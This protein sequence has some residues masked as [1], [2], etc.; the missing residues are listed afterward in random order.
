MKTKL[1]KKFDENQGTITAAV[2]EDALYYGYD[3]PQQFFEDLL[4]HGCQWGTVSSMI[5][6]YDTHKFYDKHYDEIEDIRLELQEEWI[7]WNEPIDSDLKNYY[8]WLA[9]EHVAYN[10]YNELEMEGS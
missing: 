7:L 2:I 1:Q 5:Y 4:Q 8:A 3:E 6:Y 10:I 9:Y